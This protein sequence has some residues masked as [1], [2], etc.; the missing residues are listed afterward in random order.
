VVTVWKRSYLRPAA[1]PT[2]MRLVRVMIMMSGSEERQIDESTL[3]GLMCLSV[4][5]CC[6]YIELTVSYYLYHSQAG[7]ERGCQILT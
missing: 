4:L 1:A 3:D 6:K 7:G 2:S 5:H